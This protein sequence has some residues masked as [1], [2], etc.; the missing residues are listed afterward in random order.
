MG[1]YSSVNGSVKM[2]EAN[3]NALMKVR[4][5]LPSFSDRYSLEDYFEEISFHE[6]VCN[7]DSYSK[8]YDLER[9]VGVLACFK[10]GEEADEIVYQGDTGIDDSGVYF[11]LPGK[12]TYAG[13]Q[14]P[15]IGDV[16]EGAWVRTMRPDA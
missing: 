5:K 6:G 9:I 12:W 8:H 14:Y 13:I 2:S 15:V 11:I 16:K 7:I 3:F 1:Y 10:E 4:V